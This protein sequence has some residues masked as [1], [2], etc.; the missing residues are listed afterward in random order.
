MY[1]IPPGPLPITGFDMLG[2]GI[3]GSALIAVGFL[4]IRLVVF[5]RSK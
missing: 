2:F 1:P 3:A 5:S 4:L